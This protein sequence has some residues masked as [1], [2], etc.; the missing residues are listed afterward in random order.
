[1]NCPYCGKEIQP[2]WK[3][4]PSCA[5]SLTENK[6]VDEQPSNAPVK[7]IN[8]KGKNVV[9]AILVLI[10]VLFAIGLGINLENKPPATSPSQS[11]TKSATSTD[12]KAETKPPAKVENWQYSEKDDTIHNAKFKFAQTT[13]INTLN[14]KFPYTGVQHAHMVIRK[15]YDGSKDA[16]ITIEKGQFMTSVLGGKALIRFDDNPPEEFQLLGTKDNSTTTVFIKYAD[17]FIKN[18]LKSKK[19][20]IQ[21]EF[22]Q[23]GSPTLEFNVEGLN[24]L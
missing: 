4:C 9:G 10:V 21:T 16:M 3:F 15:N 12:N 13:S 7:N 11:A 1:M 5:K 22:Y 19:V 18:I 17:Y 8:S 24:D 20:Y 23:E 2:D 14:F 6:N